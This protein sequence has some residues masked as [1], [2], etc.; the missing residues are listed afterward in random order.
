MSHV[1]FKKWFLK[2]PWP[3]SLLGCPHVDFTKYPM[4]RSISRNFRKGGLAC[5][6][7]NRQGVWGWGP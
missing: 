2:L 1:E 3:M 7:P 4:S 6:S 5:V